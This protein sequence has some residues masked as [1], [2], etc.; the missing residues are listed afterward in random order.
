ML[1]E[2]QNSLSLIEIKAKDRSLLQ[3]ESALCVKRK[4]DGATR[5]MFE[6]ID[7][8][9]SNKFE[10]LFFCG[11][12]PDEEIGY[13]VFEVPT[14]QIP[15]NKDYKMA[16]MFRMGPTI[17]DK[18]DDFQP[19]VIHISTPSPL[20]YFALKYGLKNQLP[21]TTI[22]HT[23]FISYVEYYTKKTPLLTSALKSAMIQH[24]KS[25]Y[26]RCTRVYVPTDAIAEELEGYRFHR[27][28]MK[29]WPRGIK[30]ELFTPDKRDINSLPDKA[31]N[32]N[33]N[34]LFV[35]RLVWEKNLELLIQIQ[36]RIEERQLP[37]NL[38]VA[39][40]GVAEE[41]LKRRMP[42][43]IFTG[44]VNHDQL[45]TLYASS[46]YFL[47]TST[48]E[49]YGNVITEAMASGTPCVIANGG[50]SRSLV[51]EGI[52]G[53]LC[54]PKDADDFLNK[55]VLLEAYPESRELMIK[56][57]LEDAGTLNWDALVYRLQT[58]IT[59]LSNDNNRVSYS[60]GH[61]RL[62]VA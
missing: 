8:F 51:K 61:L 15:I 39:G 60:T 34:I 56:N 22:Y 46:D 27:D 44:H 5:T 7:R 40:S 52:T 29:L 10:I 54:D 37:F 36:N 13:E 59:N 23:H 16:S 6:I 25:F 18:L 33:R 14:L 17:V 62:V 53:Y 32:N 42:N 24:N 12:P 28:N 49:T 48:T 11:V 38:I 1:K 26:N 57:A 55:I 45:S 20:G 30:L 19:D 31:Q 58:E 41:E 21:V 2:S 35:S 43:A 47:F 50:G 4:Y 9:D 3:S